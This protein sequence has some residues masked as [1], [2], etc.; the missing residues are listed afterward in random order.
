[1]LKVGRW[2]SVLIDQSVDDVLSSEVDLGDNY[3]FLTVIQPTL[4]GA[5]TVTI[6]AA[7]GSGGTF[8]PLHGLDGDSTGDHAQITT[9][10]T[11]TRAYTF[12]IGGVQYIKILVSTGVTTDKTFYVRGFNRG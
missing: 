7:M 5:H 9:G 11:T 4:D 10:A 12:R 3:E 2:I 6:T 1:M 8:Y